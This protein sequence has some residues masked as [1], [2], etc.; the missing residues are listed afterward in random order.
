MNNLTKI[1]KEF[2]IGLGF[3]SYSALLIVG[4]ITFK[5]NPELTTIGKVIAVAGQFICYLSLA[6]VI[7]ALGKFLLWVYMD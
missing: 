7:R 3:L 2:L 6:L 5:E 4:I 1:L